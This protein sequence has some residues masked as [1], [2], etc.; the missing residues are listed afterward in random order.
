MG[1]RTLMFL[2]DK[3]RMRLNSA[4]KNALHEDT[5]TYQQML[6]Q[7]DTLE[8]K[9]FMLLREGFTKKECSQRLNMKRSHVGSHVKSIYLK[10]NVSSS[11]ELIIKYREK[12]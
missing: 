11:A 1:V 12:S 5:R 8:Y 7:L 6:S 3:I 9:I 2:V 10:L 4:K